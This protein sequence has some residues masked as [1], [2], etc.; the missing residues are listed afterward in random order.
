M[1]PYS[2]IVPSVSVS[3]CPVCALTFESYN[4][5]TSFFGMHTHLQ[6]TYVKFACEG[7][8]I[9]VKGTGAKIVICMHY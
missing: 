9:K 2:I 1:K 3:V 4:L 6:N 5:E 7:H 8:R